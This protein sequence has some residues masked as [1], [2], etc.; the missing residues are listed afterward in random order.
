MYFS[1][2]ILILLSINIG[3]VWILHI[4]F[5]SFYHQWTQW[6][7]EPICRHGPH[8]E[9]PEELVHLGAQRE[10]G[11]IAGMQPDGMRNTRGAQQIS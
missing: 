7:A 1:F 6:D 10:L 8:Q 11:E 5:Q 4:N 9:A 2:H 3:I